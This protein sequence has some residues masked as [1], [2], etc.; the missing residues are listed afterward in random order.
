[1]NV[2]K[3]RM[4]GITG[5][6]IVVAGLLLA[7]CGFPQGSSGGQGGEGVFGEPT[8]EATRPGAELGWGFTHTAASA[9]EG[10]KKAVDRAAGVLDD[11]KLPQNQHIMGWGAANPEPS[12]G[13]YD[14]SDLDRRVDLMRRTG[15]PPVITLCCA[16]DWMKED[17]KQGKTDWGELETAPSPRYYD[18]FAE[19]AGKVAKRYPDVRHFIVWNEL[20]GFYDDSRGQWDYEGYTRLY[21][22]VYTELKKVNQDNLV[23]GPYVVMDSVGKASVNASDETGP[24][25]A[26]DQRA[27]DVVRYWNKHKKGADFAVVDGPTYSMDDRYVP[28][29]FTATEKLTAVSRWV[30]KETKLPLWWAEWYVETGDEN[31]ERDAWSEQHRLAVQAAGLAAMARGGTSTGF[32]WNPQNEGAKCA[33]C[34]WRS[35]GLGDGGG[36]LPMMRLLARFDKEFGPGTDFEKVSVADDDRPNVSVLAD[37][38]AVLVVNKLGRKI[39]A[40]VDGQSFEL[41]GYGVRWL[42]RKD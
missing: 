36:E 39:Q 23:G 38:D 19:L 30:R 28:D 34:L 22:R 21:N 24:W 27:L 32:Y 42:D 20:K 33:G 7:M 15:K 4:A 2:A 41:K 9:D 35:T 17:G 10:E 11:A 26:L 18:D 31:D 40:K 1:M 3:S 14:F 29:E 25:G 12:P 8:P 13:S 37:D 5:A 6:A 16:P